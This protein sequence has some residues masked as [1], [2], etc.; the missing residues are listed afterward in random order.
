MYEEIRQSEKTA[1]FHPAANKTAH[2]ILPLVLVLP[3]RMQVTA[4][5]NLSQVLSE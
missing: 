2:F 3:G 1:I 4:Y 5:V